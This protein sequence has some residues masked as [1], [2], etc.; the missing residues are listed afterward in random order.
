M[1]DQAFRSSFVYTADRWAELAV[2]CR[3]WNGQRWVLACLQDGLNEL[4]VYARWVRSFIEKEELERLVA[5]LV[6]THTST[7]TL[8]KMSAN[9]NCVRVQVMLANKQHCQV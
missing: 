6:H 1:V 8:W 2:G 4:G 3:R 9:A 7:H 5:T